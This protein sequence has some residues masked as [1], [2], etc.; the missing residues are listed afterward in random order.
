[1]KR[2]KV[3]AIEVASS[4]YILEALDVLVSPKFGHRSGE[5]LKKDI[6]LLK[7]EY[8]DRISE[9]LYDYSVLA[10]MGEARHAYSHSDYFC[11]IEEGTKNTRTVVCSNNRD[12]SYENAKD[13]NPSNALKMLE[14]LFLGF[15]WEEGY[16]GEKWGYI[17]N[18]VSLFGSID[19]TAFCDMCFS[20]SHNSSPYL[21]KSNIGIF[22]MKNITKYEELLNIKL[23]KSLEE[24]VCLYAFHT[25]RRLYGLI[26]R[27]VTLGY[28]KVNMAFIS[29]N[30]R[31]L[32]SECETRVLGYEKISYGK[33]NIEIE[34]EY[35]IGSP[36]KER[37]EKILDNSNDYN[38]LKTGD[39]CFYEIE[40][41]RGCFVGVVT[42][43]PVKIL[44]HSF[45]VSTI[46][47]KPPL[48]VDATQVFEIGDLIVN[49]TRRVQRVVAIDMK[50]GLV[51]CSD[52][53][54]NRFVYPIISVSRIDERYFSILNTTYDDLIITKKDLECLLLKGKA[55][56]CH[57]K[58]L[59]K[60][61][62]GD[63][64]GSI[65]GLFVVKSFAST[66]RS[67]VVEPIGALKTKDEDSYLGNVI[68]NK[69]L[70]GDISKNFAEI[71]IFSL[72]K[73]M[74][75]GDLKVVRAMPE[76]IIFHNCHDNT[77]Y[78]LDS[79]NKDFHSLK[80]R[81]YQT[82]DDDI[83]LKKLLKPCYE[84]F[85]KDLTYYKQVSSK[86]I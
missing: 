7:K 1:M 52:H 34:P 8:T 46:E 36:F 4:F 68:K 69:I 79:F 16:G 37:Y 28:L 26:K 49:K 62:V 56:L 33:K 38:F 13:Y 24:L 31:G 11:E 44:N 77:D 78:F 22:E 64:V 63:L 54:E 73:V 82:K 42:H 29:K 15:E 59:S 71:S 61:K 23:L 6:L 83:Y 57:K 48:H 58:G 70:S 80:L 30:K 60:F 76:Y 10:L 74:F 20:L 72:E 50:L 25:G 5:K 51:L 18:R 32:R 86:K 9:M 35:E 14:K 40:G 39:D 67:V 66:F 43:E 21:D 19:N 45:C 85:E 17:A 2:I 3:E 53:E 41:K 27:A 65:Y 84:G 47:G 81:D 12:L 55:T 75:V